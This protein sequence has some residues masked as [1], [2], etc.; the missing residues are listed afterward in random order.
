VVSA[1]LLSLV[2]ACLVQ[3]NRVSF[4]AG[5]TTI[6]YRLQ[7]GEVI[8]TIPTIGFNV[9]TLTYKNIKFQVY[10]SVQTHAALQ[11]MS[12]LPSDSI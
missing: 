8:T 11:P 5:K 10:V 3:S 1:S 9:E 12:K 2:L 6:L 4:P 7:I